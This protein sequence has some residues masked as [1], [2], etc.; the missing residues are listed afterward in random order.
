MSGSSSPLIAGSSRSVRGS[1]AIA[2]RRVASSSPTASSSQ[3]PSLP[4]PLQ[5]SMV[6]RVD[7]SSP[8]IH[9]GSMPE[10]AGHSCIPPTPSRVDAHARAAVIN[11]FRAQAVVARLAALDLA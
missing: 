5:T 7:G 2:T 6:R 8:W 10:R 4:F 9:A 3:F 1:P 11:G